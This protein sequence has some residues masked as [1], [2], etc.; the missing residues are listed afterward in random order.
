MEGNEECHHEV[1]CTNLQRKRQVRKKWISEDTLKL[2]EEKQLAFRRWQEERT[3]LDRRREYTN[4]CKNV[5]KAI[6]EDKEK[7]LNETIMEMEEDMRQ[8]RQGNF[9]KKMKLLTRS[10]VTPSNTILNEASRPLQKADEKLARRKRYF[11]EMLNV[12]NTLEEEAMAGLQ[13]HSGT[14]TPEV[15]R[16]EV[17]RAVKKL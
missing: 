17:E 4:C 2:I 3:N 1:R 6:R 15:T 5:R 14:G 7:W 16:E 9:F 11:E 13:D 12:Q 8:H 10:K